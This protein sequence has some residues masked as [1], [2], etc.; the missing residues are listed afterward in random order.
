MQLA[1][2]LDPPASILEI[3]A[4]VVRQKSPLR[5][6]NGHHIGKVF[7]WLVSRSERKSAELIEMSAALCQLDF[8]SESFV[9][10][11]EQFAERLTGYLDDLALL[12]RLVRLQSTS[13]IA[14]RL[15]ESQQRLASV[16]A[17]Q[18]MPHS[19][20]ALRRSSLHGV[21]GSMAISPVPPEPIRTAECILAAF[22]PPVWSAAERG[23]HRIAAA[24]ARTEVTE[25]LHRNATRFR[26]WMVN[27]ANTGIS[28]ALAHHIC[29]CA[30]LEIPSA[31]EVLNTRLRPGWGLGQPFAPCLKARRRCCQRLRQTLS[32]PD[33]DPEENLAECGR[34]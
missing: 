29:V 25:L 7:G 23:G 14:A 4:E 8:R 13:R 32:F 17:R 6:E 12:G 26:P 3:S 18:L 27:P 1:A 21:V 28:A 30:R 16:L 5:F 2:L 10:P 15:M 9:H 19:L 33:L 31:I 11:A 20:E 34:R 24:G 22:L